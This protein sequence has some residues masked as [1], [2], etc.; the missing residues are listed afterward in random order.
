MPQV[1]LPQS[2]SAD[3][4]SDDKERDDSTRQ[5][6][7]DVAYRQIVL[8]NVVFVGL[9]HAG[10][11]NWVLIDAGLAGSAARYQVNSE[12]PLWRQR[13]AGRHRPDA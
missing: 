5:I 12:G 10:D 13:P 3:R 8:V 2:A 1:S 7:H 9:P 6:A 4:P 11:G